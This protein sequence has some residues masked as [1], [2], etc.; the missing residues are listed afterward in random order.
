MSP[1]PVTHIGDLNEKFDSESASEKALQEY[2]E[3]LYH[4]TKSLPYSP[5][6]LEQ[7]LEEGKRHEDVAE[8]IYLKEKISKI[9]I[10]QSRSPAAQK[11]LVAVL[12]TIK[13]SY[14]HKV[15]PLIDQKKERHLI[16]AAIYENVITPAY[17][18]LE[19]NP[20]DLSHEDI[21]GMIYY[22]AG[23]CHLNWGNHANL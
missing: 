5:K 21:T 20:L 10:A 15:K 12:A 16:D 1:Q 8:A 2:I 7:K 9:I 19:R 3:D 6:T 11:I 14:I 13:Q 18:F 22:L 17:L 23:T 4:F